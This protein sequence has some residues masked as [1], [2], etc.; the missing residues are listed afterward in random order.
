MSV[1]A[2]PEISSSGLVM[3]LDAGN[4]NKSA[5]GFKNLLDL[6]TWTLGTGGV[7]GFTQNGI[8][9]E[10]QRILDTGPFGISALVWDTPS[11]DVTS[12]ADGGWDGGTISI[13]ATKRYRFSVWIRR[14]IIGNGAYYLGCAGGVLNRSDGVLNN[15][16]YFSAA[17]WPASIL[18]NE[19][20][21][22]VGHIFP[23]GSGTGTNHADSGLWNTS[24]TKFSGPT[25]SGDFVFQ[26]SATTTSLRSYLYYSTDTTTN[27]QWYQPRIDLCDGT[28]PTIA[29]LIAGVGSK[30][31]DVSG[32]GNHGNILNSAAL[33]NSAGY[34]TFDGVDDS[35]DIT[36]S[37]QLGSTSFTLDFWLQ[38]LSSTD[39]RGIFSWNADGFNTSAKGL[40]I[41]FR[42][43]GSIEYALN[44]GVGTAT[45]L[46]HSGISLNTW[47]NI[48]YTHNYNG[49]IT[50]YRNGVPITSVDYSTEGNSS[51]A[52]TYPFRLGYCTNGFGN[53]RLANFKFYNRVL[54]AAEVLQNFN[55][56]KGR[57]G[58]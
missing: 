32:I 35:V 9:A 33:Y 49:I 17:N 29:E 40:S 45:R 30:I 7:A 21:L 47:Y 12:D 46:T 31:Y 53:I 56:T 28:E 54:S 19:W 51:F 24:G 14:K 38:I 4:P 39:A 1:Y 50:T 22:V 15:N 52:D 8:T 23:A 25:S 20:M 36:N 44:D 43:A 34:M 3:C 55:A 48:T 27:Q 37:Y 58:I 11:N 13:D 16:P 41:R 42:N 5:K 6:S 26:T 57:F 10:N 18:A 2:G